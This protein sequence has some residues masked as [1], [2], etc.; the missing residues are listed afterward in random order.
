MSDVQQQPNWAALVDAPA[1]SWV[2]RHRVLWHRGAD[3][4]DGRVVGAI[5]PGIRGK[6]V[7]FIYADQN[8]SK[9]VKTALAMVLA[10]L[11]PGEF[12]IN[13]GSGGTKVHD[14]LINVD[15][16]PCNGIDV[17][18][19]DSRLP[20]RDR[21]ISIIVAQEVLEHIADFRATIDEVL[22][23]LKPGGTFYCQTPF[24]IGFHPGPTDFW[25]FSRQGVEQCFSGAGWS[26]EKVEISVGYAT[27]FYR[28]LI[29][30]VAVTAS[31]LSQK[32]YI[33]AKAAAALVFYPLKL[34][35]PLT[36]YSQERDRIPG[37]YLAIVRKAL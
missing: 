33:P 17:V 26:V 31:L 23:V 19:V 9:A 7:K 2:W 24:Q 1:D 15:V 6:F 3:T 29:E 25:R 22:R 18:V 12:G 8:Q 5:P 27:G 14:S 35:D 36:H 10:R 13:L 32:L 30:F 4:F 37:G 11:G 28:I 20:F 16:T 21:S 34:L